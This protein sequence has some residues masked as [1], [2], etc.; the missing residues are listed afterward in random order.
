MQN[1]WYGQREE[2]RQKL[3]TSIVKL[4]FIRHWLVVEW[5]RKPQ[6]AFGSNIPLG[7]QP[8]YGIK[9]GINDMLEY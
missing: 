8:G 4:Y 9:K 2:H 1:E 5:L 6:P 7:W 3:D